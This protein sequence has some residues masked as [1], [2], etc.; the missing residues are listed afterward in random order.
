MASMATG[1]HIKGLGRGA[2]SELSSK[3]KRLGMTPERYVKEL[4]QEDLALDRK[5]QATTLGDLMGSG[6]DI[7]E[8]E[9]DKLVNAARRRHHRRTSRKK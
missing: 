1:L 3:A 4:L 5:A 7:D 8:D 6:R 2:M 9:L